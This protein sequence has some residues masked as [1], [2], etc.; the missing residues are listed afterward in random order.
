MAT[1]IKFNQRQ[2]DALVTLIYNCGTGILSNDSDIINMFVNHFISSSNSKQLK[3][4]NICKEVSMK[5]SASDSAANVKTISKGATLKLASA[6]M[7][8]GK[9]YYKM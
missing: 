2:F 1:R 7:Y 8:R 3:V 6:S 5:K 9:K 4:R